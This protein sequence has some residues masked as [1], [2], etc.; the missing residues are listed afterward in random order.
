MA[1]A[2]AGSVKPRPVPSRSMRAATDPI[3]FTSPRNVP[4]MT[5][6]R[7]SALTSCVFSAEIS[8]MAAN[9]SPAA[10]S[11]LMA[12]SARLIRTG[13]PVPGSNTGVPL[14]A[15]I[16][17][18]ISRSVGHASAFSAAWPRSA[19][20]RVRRSKSSKA[21]APAA[22]RAPRAVSRTSGPKNAAYSVRKRAVT[23]PA[24]FAS[25]AV[26][27][28][29]P[30]PRLSVP[31]SRGVSSVRKAKVAAK[32]LR[33]PSPASWRSRLGRSGTFNRPEITPPAASTR[34]SSSV[35]A[36][37]S[38]AKLPATLNAA[39]CPS[40][41]VAFKVISPA[42]PDSWA[43]PDRDSVTASP[44]SGAPSATLSIAI[45][46]ITS[47]AGRSGRA[48]GAASGAGAA[49]GTGNGART[50]EISAAFR[51]DISMAPRSSAA[52]FQPMATS[53]NESQ[54][55]SVSATVIWS[56]VAVLLNAPANPSIRTIR[57][58]PPRASS[59]RPVRYPRS[60]SALCACKVSGQIRH[61]RRVS[62][63]IKTTVQSR[64]KSQG[65]PRHRG[66]MREPPCQS[67]SAQCRCHSAR[68]L[69][70]RCAIHR[71]FRRRS[72]Q[73][74]YSLRRRNPRPTV[75]ARS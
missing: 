27:S 39:V 15:A 30:A 38:L 62:T 67:V 23:S 45:A 63:R 16:A 41:R 68:L 9:V 59:S 21:M 52:R 43:L 3:A 5:S 22:S 44:K 40:V 12:R 14:G 33:S 28:S 58:S 13:A 51:S 65:P 49:L 34:S 6:L 37:V 66:L 35:N 42:P 24:R 55:P 64:C 10:A 69:R 29:L 48:K 61:I 47:D 31:F 26:A 19:S 71:N 74:R 18:S 20:A 2:S 17:P 4:S 54:T 7:S 1:R 60:S 25:N 8:T 36:R 50:T 57:P 72:S 73:G 46:S 56:M 53:F 75:S 11:K 70:C 32:S